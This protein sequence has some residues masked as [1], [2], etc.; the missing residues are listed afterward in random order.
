[1][2]KEGEGRLR[3]RRIVAKPAPCARRMNQLL[4]RLSATKHSPGL[5]V[6]EAPASLLVLHRTCASRS[7]AELTPRLPLPSPTT[8]SARFILCLYFLFPS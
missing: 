3:L 4:L 8:G 2:A 5:P 1:M 6:V 7:P